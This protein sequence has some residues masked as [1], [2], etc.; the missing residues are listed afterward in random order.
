[1]LKSNIGVQVSGIFTLNLV[2]NDKPLGARI[3]FAKRPVCLDVVPK[4]A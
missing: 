1:M 2:D 4:V 3:I